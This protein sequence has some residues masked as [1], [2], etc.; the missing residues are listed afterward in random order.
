MTYRHILYDVADRVATITFN[1]PEARNFLD[2]PLLEEW[3][4]ALRAAE[5]DD[6]VRVV[7][8]RGAGP[9]FCAGY[10]MDQ[11][12]EYEDMTSFDGWVGRHDWNEKISTTWE[13]RKPVIAQVHG[14]CVS[15]G[16]E[17][18]G[19]CD[20]TIAAETARFYNPHA[21]GWALSYLHLGV[22]HM[23]PQWTK[24]MMYT[25]DVISGAVAER[26]G[27]VAK[28][29]P[30]DRLEETVRRLAARIALVPAELLA[31]HKASVNRVVEYMGRRHAL[32]T[33]LEL[34]TIARTRNRFIEEFR[35]HA[36][37]KGWK[38][39]FDAIDRPFRELPLPF[40]EPERRKV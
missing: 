3:V 18:I 27:L 23:G 7:V 8:L 9:A 29:V 32:E 14:W 35:A 4:H 12:R 22:Y 21:R 11:S 5:S 25:G 6:L 1:R 26:I 31:L 39:A 28:A 10:Q 37:E 34:D 24:L 13:L 30:E 38:E 15:G 36:A 20:S 17:M 19:Q 40:D 33:G 2:E 16:V